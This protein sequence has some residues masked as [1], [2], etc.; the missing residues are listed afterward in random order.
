M[1]L[2]PQLLT[3]ASLSEHVTHVELVLKEHVEH[4]RTVLL[5]LDVHACVS[6]AD[7]ER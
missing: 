5:A 7:E 2:W 1:V 4:L 3:S 6:E